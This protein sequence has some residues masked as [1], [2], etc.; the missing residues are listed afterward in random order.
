MFIDA[1]YAQNQSSF[2]SDIGKAFAP[3]LKELTSFI[4]LIGL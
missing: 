4:S 1:N 3:L 2:R